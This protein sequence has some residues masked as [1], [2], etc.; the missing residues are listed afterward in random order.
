M[1]KC[2]ACGEVLFSSKEKYESGSGWP[3]F[4]DVIEKGR[5]ELEEDTSHGMVRTE[6]K[7]G[8]CGSHLGHLFDVGPM[9]TGQTYCI[10]STALEFEEDRKEK[11]PS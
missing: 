9:P 11:K 8:N 1:Y 3:S 6:V 7:C 4:Y 10:N 5:I 2:T